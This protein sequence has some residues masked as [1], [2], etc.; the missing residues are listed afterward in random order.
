MKWRYLGKFRFYIRERLE[1]KMCK[2]IIVLGGRFIYL[3]IW[4][5]YF[6]IVI[7]VI[8]EGGRRG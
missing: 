3:K 1:L 6:N 8:I 2:I 5:I 7:Y 4:F